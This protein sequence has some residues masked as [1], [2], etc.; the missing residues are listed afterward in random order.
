MEILKLIQSSLELFKVVEI[1]ES[2]RRIIV[3]FHKNLENRE[4][5]I[6]KF[7]DLLSKV[8]YCNKYYSCNADLNAARN[9]SQFPPISLKPISFEKK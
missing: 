1:T 5:K 7:M 4:E 9:I 3:K 6:K 8:L 2:E